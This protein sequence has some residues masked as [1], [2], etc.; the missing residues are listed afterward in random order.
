MEVASKKQ[1]KVKVK[2]P[3]YD[4]KILDILATRNFK[5]RNVYSF[6]FYVGEDYLVNY[7]PFQDL[8]C[9]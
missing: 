8:F 3:A 7:G 1:G 9:G 2:L 4:N 6:Q 5:I